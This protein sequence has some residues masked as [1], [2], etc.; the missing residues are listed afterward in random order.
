MQRKICAIILMSIILVPAVFAQNDTSLPPLSVYA[1]S[2]SSLLMKDGMIFTFPT[3]KPEVPVFLPESLHLASAV[4][5]IKPTLSITAEF[6]FPLASQQARLLSEPEGQLHLARI[7]RSV[8]RL[9]GITYWS[10]S[11]GT[12]R[13]LF[14]SA[15]ILG[16]T[17]NLLQQL[18]P[19]PRV[20]TEQDCTAILDDTTFGKQKYRFTYRADSEWQSISLTNLQ[21]IN[22]LFVPVIK[23]EGMVIIL[24]M[25]PVAEGLYVWGLSMAKTASLLGIEKN[26]EDSLK[27]RLSALAA[28]LSTELQDF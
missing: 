8:G 23:A 17:G 13:V 22:L 14:R 15:A 25:K 4:E 21:T 12:E 16:D 26:F 7:I 11:H 18:D 5:K 2:K 28:W 10:V 6:F 20:P 27:N 1:G 9:S 3:G 24:V 19:G